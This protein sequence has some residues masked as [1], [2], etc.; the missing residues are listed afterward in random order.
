MCSNID[1]FVADTHVAA[2][3]GNATAIEGVPLA[4]RAPLRLQVAGARHGVAVL[5]LPTPPAT[6]GQRIVGPLAA[7]PSVEGAVQH[8]ERATLEMRR[9]RDGSAVSGKAE[10]RCLLQLHVAVLPQLDAVVNDWFA[11]VQASLPGEMVRAT[12]DPRPSRT[13]SL[14]PPRADAT[15]LRHV[16]CDSLARKGSAASAHATSS[17]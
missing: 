12:G 16:L 10:A 14:A 11:L 17:A 4:P 6:P 9:L 15:R 3:S 1:F 13:P 5:V 8:V 7:G 2:T